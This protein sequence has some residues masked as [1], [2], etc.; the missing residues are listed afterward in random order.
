M[1]NLLQ[2]HISRLSISHPS[3]ASHSHCQVS[4]CSRCSPEP[5]AGNASRAF[6]FTS[7]SNHCPSHTPSNP[8]TFLAS[9][10]TLPRSQTTANNPATTA[11]SSS[12]PL[13]VA[14]GRHRP[15]TTTSWHQM[16][17]NSAYTYA[18]SLRTQPDQLKHPPLLLALPRPSC[19]RTSASWVR[20]HNR[21]PL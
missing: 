2:L 10:S 5:I 9:R 6:Q 21:A 20:E 13:L 8:H 11:Q 1:R 15:K 14:V 3:L 19:W 18:T 4:P 7:H 16:P 17:P 12:P